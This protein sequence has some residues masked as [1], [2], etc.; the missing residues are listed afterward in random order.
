MLT[1]LAG[2]NDPKVTHLR[3]QL[4]MRNPKGILKRLLSSFQ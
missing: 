2:D 1:E 3:E 4:A